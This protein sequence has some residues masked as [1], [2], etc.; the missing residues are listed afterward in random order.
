MHEWL[1]VIIVLLILGVLLDGILRMRKMRH[2]KIRP[3]KSVNFDE[4]D[5]PETTSEFPSGGARVAGY[6]DEADADFLND[7]FKQ[8]LKQSKKTT[9]V[10]ERQ[11]DF[12]IALE[13]QSALPGY[14]TE[15][16]LY[17]DDANEPTIGD[18]DA[19]GEQASSSDSG[20][21]HDGLSKPRARVRRE[22]EPTPREP[23]PEVISEPR[24]EAREP[25][26]ETVDEE[27]DNGGGQDDLNEVIVI[28]VVANPGYVFS[29]EDLLQAI[30]DE[31]LR[32]G[33]M[34]I[35]HRHEH[36]DG[37]GRVMFS[38]ANMLK[39][40]TFDLSNLA[41]FETPGVSLF[42]HLPVPHDSLAAFRTMTKVAKSLVTALGG[43]LKDENRSV[44][45]LTIVVSFSL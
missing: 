28:H 14:Q 9:P 44:I 27:M 33:D 16:D 2:D 10:R 18:L 35:F 37:S 12:D 40:G 4:G 5:S 11:L 32:F 29:G 41:S 3:S 25:A 7:I 39:P 8:N 31:G 22:R 23:T 19:L 45:I 38:M 42:M 13:S 21:D 26:P 20:F 24:V 34:D 6:R 36:E 30:T 1:S 43:E 17:R 15:N